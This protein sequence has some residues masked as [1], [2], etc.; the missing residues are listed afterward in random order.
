[1]LF[2]AFVT[3]QQHLC[4]NE[5]SST[6]NKYFAMAIQIANVLESAAVDELMRNISNPLLF[7]HKRCCSIY[8]IPSVDYRRSLISPA[9]YV[10]DVLACWNQ[11]SDAATYISTHISKY[12]YSCCSCVSFT[13][14]LWNVLSLIL[15]LDN[16]QNY[17]SPIALFGAIYQNR[18]VW[19]IVLSSRINLLTRWILYS[20]VGLLSIKTQFYI[21]LLDRA[22][23]D[24]SLY[25]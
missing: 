23:F 12:K 9:V 4:V 17:I 16:S 25:I 21:K 14:A 7:L 2:A 18:G 1:M 22:D 11:P 8:M 19:P 10:A 20:N 5:F 24:C 13:A 6:C 3:Q 15:L